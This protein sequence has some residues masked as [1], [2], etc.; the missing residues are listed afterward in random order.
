[1][2]EWLGEHMLELFGAVTGIIYVILEIRQNIL[3][4]PLGII[5]SA[6]YIWV[7]GQKGFYAGMVLQGYYVAI[8]IYGWYKWHRPKAL[9]DPP[10]G[11]SV[12]GASGNVIS[13]DGRTALYC[14]LSALLLWV[15]LWYLLDRWTDSPVPLW[16]GLITSL[17]VVATW[18]L[19]RKYLEQWYVWIVANSVAVIVYLKMGMF[20]T[21]ALFMVYFVMAV[22]GVRAW[23]RKSAAEIN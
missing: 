7:F 5:T 11:G 10:A 6:V 23:K 21:A 15:L 8:S 17:S 4:W 20:P 2:N 9:T 22:I 3:L 14:L 12:S 18:M 16:D 1:M 13:V 19:T